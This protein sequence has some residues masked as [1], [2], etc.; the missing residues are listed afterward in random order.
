MDNRYTAYKQ[1]EIGTANRGKLVVMLFSGAITFLSKAKVAMQKNDYET[2]GKYIIKAMNIIDELNISLD[3][4]KGQD[5]AKNL[6]SIYL[7]LDRY[8]SQANIENDPEKI[9]RAINIIEKIKSA[10]EEVLQ[11]TEAQALNKVEQTQN[12]IKKTV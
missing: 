7:F 4:E 2:K 9:D 5:I 11:D 1:Q 6:K 12:L 10:F 8:L 3:M